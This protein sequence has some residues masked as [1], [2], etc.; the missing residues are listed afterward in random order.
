MNTDDTIINTLDLTKGEIHLLLSMIG[1]CDVYLLS[2][3]LNKTMQS[4]SEIEDAIPKLLRICHKL[5]RGL[6]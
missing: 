6:S 1:A 5:E 3:I 4:E 2:H